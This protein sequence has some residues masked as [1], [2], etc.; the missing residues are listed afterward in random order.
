MKFKK[1]AAVLM[2]AA[3]A[4]SAASCGSSEEENDAAQSANGSEVVFTVGNQTVT[5]NELNA[6]ITTYLNTDYT[7][8]EAKT[9]ASE[10]VA[11]NAAMIALVEAMGLEYTDEEKEAMAEQKQAM[12]DN[13]GSQSAYEDFLDTLG[14]TDE[15]IDTMLEAQY[16]EEKIFADDLTDDALK[17][18]YNDRYFRAKHILFTTMDTTTYEEYDDDKKAEQKALAEEILARAQ[19]GEDFDTLMN[20]YSE[21]PGTESNPDGYYFTYDEMVEEFEDTVVELEENEIGFCE[22][23]YGYHI[24]K[25]LPLEEG[26]DAYEEAFEG[27]RQTIKSKVIRNLVENKLPQLLEEYGLEIVTN[28]EVLDSITE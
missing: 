14:F 2:S 19:A 17:D 4:L 25:R 18:Y 12:I 3:L 28:Q 23:D 22:S 10:D 26:S 13:Y 6:Y 5:V 16:A 20:E 11:N 27:V 1:T 7:F 15:N 24:I 9:Y 21:D 8:D